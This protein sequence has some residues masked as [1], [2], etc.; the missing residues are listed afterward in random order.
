MSDVRI[1]QQRERQLDAIST[2]LVLALL[3]I[4]AMILYF[5]STSG[6]QLPGTSPLA[7]YVP[8]V[9]L[10]GFTIMLLLY[11]ADQRRRLHLQVT[12]AVAETESARSSLATTVRWLT[13]SHNSASVLGAEG[14][15]AGLKHVLADA[16]ALLNADA[17]AVLGTEFAVAFIA[18]G[19]S[20]QEA[21]RAFVRVALEA[22]GRS[23]PLHIHSLGAGRGQAIAVPLRVSGELRF[24]LC[25]WRRC[26]PFE[27]EQLDSLGLMGRMVELA[28]ERGE[29][30]DEAQAQLEGTL[31][32]LQY[33]VADKRPNYSRHVMRVADMAAEI[34]RHMSV[35]P[36]S[37]KSLRLAGLIHDV[38]IMGM[39]SDMADANRELT[40][41]EHLV[42]RQHPRIGSEIALAAHFDASVQEAVAGHHERLDGSGYPKGLAGD[43]ISLGARILGV[44]EVFDSMA[45]RAYHGEP[46]GVA[47]AI[48]ELHQNA[49]VL[50]DA[51]VVRVLVETIVP[52]DRMRFAISDLEELALLLNS[53]TGTIAVA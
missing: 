44:C 46:T 47:D 24:V 35:L 18:E 42:M 14:V 11:L 30:L 12:E 32:V 51:A 15:D 7:Q 52:Q 10:G 16:G 6:V 50:Y 19:V 23:E 31:N 43:E 26:E 39:P 34:G 40:S 41:E 5:L 17:A 9:L 37:R 38:G 4:V 13:F 21:E 22:V 8:R 27:S 33:L 45:E 28:I 53:D 49:G 1:V 25:A 36:R 3:I 20:E 29:L 48:K 2:T